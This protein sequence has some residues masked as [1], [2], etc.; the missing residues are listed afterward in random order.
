MTDEVSYDAK[1]GHFDLEFLN[2]GVTEQGSLEVISRYSV[3]LHQCI[4]EDFAHFYTPRARNLQA[5]N[6]VRTNL[7]CMDQQDVKLYGNY[8]SDQ[9]LNAQLLYH[10]CQEKEI[11]NR[12]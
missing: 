4:E 8:D 12:T 6:A 10:R 11:F 1:Y 9:A 5:S 7:L 2:W 3:P